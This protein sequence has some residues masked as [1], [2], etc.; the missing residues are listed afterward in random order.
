MLLAQQIH[1][2]RSWRRVYQL[3]VTDSSSR[4]PTFE[5]FLL[6]SPYHYEALDVRQLS[7]RLVRILPERSKDGLIQCNIIH[8]T[9]TTSYVCLSYVWD[10]VPMW[11]NNTD[12]RTE[13]VV[14]ING[15]RLFV[16]R[17]LFDFLCMVSLNENTRGSVSFIV[18]ATRQGK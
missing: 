6:I 9:C 14:L 1:H 2:W 3:S 13:R 7:I 4:E 15:R 17:N 16:R 10:Y 18:R 11:D 5:D 12:A 8:A